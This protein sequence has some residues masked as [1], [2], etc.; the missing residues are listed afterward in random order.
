VTHVEEISDIAELGRYRSLWNALLELTPAA[1]FFQSLEWLEVFWRHFGAGRR[2]RVL[3]GWDGEALIGILPL[4]VQPEETRV[5]TVRVLTYPLHDWGTFYGPIGPEPAAMLRLAMRY[6]RRTPRDW[7]L[8]DLR[9]VDEQ[10]S[11]RGASGASMSDA[12]FL[13]HRQ[14]WDQAAVLDMVGSWEDYWQSRTKKWRESIRRYHRRLS[15]GAAVE[16][17]RYRPGGAE[18]GGADPR[19]DLYEACLEVAGASWQG[20]S[21]TGSTLC[22][23]SVAAFLRDAHEAAVRTGSLDLCLLTRDGRP[24]AFIYN[25]RRGGRLFGLRMGFDPEFGEF[26]PGKVSQYLMFKDSFERGDEHFDMGV[27]SLDA[28]KHW[29]TSVVTSFRLTCFSP[30]TLRAQLLRLKRWYVDYRFGEAYLA[31]GKGV[32]LPA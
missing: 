21:T 23:E 6:L 2:L 28:K 15:E 22:H 24:I 5:G 30:A 19:W 29:L 13:P 3:L 32:R 26:G 16:F 27:G 14:G 7:D 20:G 18:A 17:V 11:D 31:G 4:V 9:W 8:L 10:G 25:Y 12:G 1:T